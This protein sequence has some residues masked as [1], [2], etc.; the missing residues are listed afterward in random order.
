MVT[1]RKPRRL[2][3]RVRPDPNDTGA[4]RRAEHAREVLE[5][6]FWVETERQRAIL[7]AVRSYMRSCRRTRG[8]KG[9]S[10]SGRRLSQHSQAG[11]SAIA[12]RL[13]HE[14][15]QEALAAG[16]EPNPYRVIHINIDQRMTLKALYQ[17]LLNRMADDFVD[18]PDPK[19]L[20]VSP[21]EAREIRGTSRDTMKTLEQRIEEWVIR[22]GVELVIV[23]EIQRLVTRP[24]SDDFDPENPGS[25]LT[26]DA[27]D[28]TKKLQA[29]LDRGVVPIFFIGD[30]NSPKFFRLNK[31]FAA[32]LLKPLELIPLD[33]NKTIDRKRFFDFCLEYDRQL[34]DMKVVSVPTCLTQTDVLTSLIEACGGHIGRAARIIQVALP[35]ALERGAVTLEPYDLSNAVRDYAMELGWV[36]HDPF[37]ILRVH[38]ND[39]MTDNGAEALDAA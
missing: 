35:E 23:D 19:G 6:G 39:A 15:E 33:V 36:D 13:I 21:Y 1:T 17:E 4:Q 26:A 22:L 16:Q 9:T 14:L 25:Y 10:I 8:R 38:P 30:E 5:N 34:V 37:S 11:K 12:E 28:V 3:G 32:R 20:R 2:T 31:Y 7:N 24:E 27:M 29:F 18:E